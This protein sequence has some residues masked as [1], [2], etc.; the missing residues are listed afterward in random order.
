LG[1]LLAANVTSAPL[2]ARAQAH[3]IPIPEEA[4]VTK[5]RLPSKLKFGILGKIIKIYPYL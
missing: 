2:D 4:P 5:A 1:K 3:P